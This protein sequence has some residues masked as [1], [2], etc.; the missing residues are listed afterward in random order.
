MAKP[1]KWHVDLDGTAYTITYTHRAFS[2]KVT[3]QINE[4]NFTL[5]CGEREEIFRLGDEQAILC[6]DHRG[7][8]TI[9]MKQGILEESDP[10]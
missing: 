6:I 2:G 4:E 7:K 1:Q 5:P 8:A 10:S 9:R 3:V